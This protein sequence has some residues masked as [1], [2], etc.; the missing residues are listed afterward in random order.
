[1]WQTTFELIAQIGNVAAKKHQSGWWTN[2]KVEELTNQERGEG[3]FHGG[4]GQHD[5]GHDV[6][7]EAEDRH[8]RQENALDDEPEG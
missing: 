6:P 4:P 8:G 7:D 5:D 3:T 2:I 1:M